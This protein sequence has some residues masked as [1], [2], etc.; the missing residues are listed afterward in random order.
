MEFKPVRGKQSAFGI[1]LEHWMSSSQGSPYAETKELKIIWKMFHYLHKL[2]VL[3]HSLKTQTFSKNF[4]SHAWI[5]WRSNIVRFASANLRFAHRI[6]RF[7]LVV[8]T[9]SGIDA[10]EREMISSKVSLLW[11]QLRIAITFYTLL[12]QHV[13]II[14]AN[15]NLVRAFC[16]HRVLA[17]LVYATRVSDTWN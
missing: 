15:A 2:L 10:C 6:L 1:L 14:Y 7:A 17:V 9:T 4:T 3:M 8:E 5:D 16:I 11:V 13:I 12:V